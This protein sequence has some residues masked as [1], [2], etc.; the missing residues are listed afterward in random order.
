METYPLNAVVRVG[1]GKGVARKARAS[2][3]TPGVVYSSNGAIAAVDFDV[4]DLAAAFRK[5]NDPNTL[6]DVSVGAD[7]HL[8]LVR[9]V[10]RHPV[11][12]DVLHLDLYAVS[13]D[14]LVVAEVAVN[15][16]G[17][18]AGTRSGGTMRLLARSMKMR[19]PA[20]SIPKTVDVDVTPLEVGQFLKA[21]QV[22]APAGAKF[23][24][25]QDF[26]VIAVEGKRAKEEAAPAAAEKKGK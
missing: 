17:R 20:G 11:S 6:F 23:L 22:P 18:A 1:T 19:V 16:V 9:E 5:S 12:R 2:G 4:A 13:A 3:R 26:N 14:Q 7:K 21:S 15:P 8:C 24:F 10:Q 25:K